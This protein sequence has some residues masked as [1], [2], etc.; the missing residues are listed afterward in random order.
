[1]PMYWSRIR[2][3]GRDNM[4]SLQFQ[5]HQ[6][7][8]TMSGTGQDL[9][10]DPAQVSFQTIHSVLDNH[11]FAIRYFHFLEPKQNFPNPKAELQKYQLPPIGPWNGHT[12]SGLPDAGNRLKNNYNYYSK[13]IDL[14][15]YSFENNQNESSVSFSAR[16][17]TAP[18]ILVLE[19]RNGAPADLNRLLIPEEDYS[20]LVP[21]FLQNE[22]ILFHQVAPEDLCDGYTRCGPSTICKTQDDV[23]CTCLPGFKA[24]YRHD[25]CLYCEEVPDA[26]FT[27]V[28]ADVSLKE[29]ERKCLKSCNCTGYASLNV[30]INGLVCISWYDGKLT[31]IRKF[32]DGQDFCLRV[33]AEERASTRKSQHNFEQGLLCS[34]EYRLF[35]LCL[36]WLYA[37]FTCGEDM[38]KRKVEKRNVLERKGFHDKRSGSQKNHFHHLTCLETLS[39]SPQSKIKHFSSIQDPVYS[40]MEAEKLFLL[41]SLITLQFS[42]CASQDSIETSQVIKEGDLLISKGNNFALGFFSPGSSSNRYLGIWYYKVPEKTVVWVANRNDPIIGSSGSLFINQYG[43]LI[44]YGNDDQKLPVWST[45]V[46]VEE[47]DSC[48]VQ[49]LDSGNLIMVTKRRRSII[50]Q[51]FDHPTNTLLPGMKLGVD[52][53]L[54]IDRILTSWRSADDPGIGDF[55]V[56]IN[57]TGSPQFFIYNGTKPF[58]RS[59]PWPW[60]SQMGLYKSSFVNDQDGIYSH[61]TVPDDSY[62]LKIIVDHSGHAKALARRQSDGLWKDYWKSSQFRCDYYGYCGAYSTCE[63][64]NPSEFVCACLPGFEPKYPEQWSARDGSGGCV[65]KR[66]LT[67]SVCGHGEGFVK[68]EN[69]CLPD[70]SNAAW[71]DNI[72][73]RAACELECKRNCSCSAYSIIGIPGKGDACLTWYK[74][75]VDI[76]Y[77][78]SGSDDLYVRVD[79]YELGAEGASH[80]LY[81]FPAAKNTRKSNVSH[82]KPMLAILVPSIASFW[83][84]ISISAYLWI[85]KRAKKVN[86]VNSNSIE[87]EYFKLSTITAATNNFSPANKLGQGGFGSVYKGLLANGQQVAV[88]RLS[89]SSGQGTEEFKNEVMVIAKLQHRNLVKLLG[90]CI[91]NEEEMLIYE[92][93]PNKSLD[94]FLFDETRRLLLD[95]R[96]RFDIIVGIARGILYLHQDSRLRII[97]RDL[98]CSNILLDAEMNP[99]ISDF[100]MAKIFEGNQTEDRTRRVVGTHG[101]MSP[102]YVVFGKFS[103]KSDVFSFGVMLLEIVSGKKNNRFYQ[104]NPPLTL[105]GYVWELWRQDKALEI[106]DPSLNQLYHPR[107]ALKCIQIGLLCVQEDAMDRPSMLAVVLMLSSETEIPSPKQPAFLFRESHN[108]PDIALAV[109]D[110]LCSINQDSRACLIDSGH[111]PSCGVDLEIAG[112]HPTGPTPVTTNFVAPIK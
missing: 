104:Q 56:R 52:Q 84:L 81:S 3:S 92:H 95:W 49:L 42:W 110:G 61:Y 98:K 89:R 1:M 40:V 53:K 112:M 60:R 22:D 20:T 25:W 19:P 24:L 80:N 6:L 76:R 50:W 77:D 5:D 23:Q 8:S 58:A 108:N 2:E 82:E 111:S 91:H 105:I 26:R 30:T 21:R 75:L 16:N 34:L 28:Y 72:K 18:S 29:C 101:Y 51:S 48:E 69:Y 9:F 70:T 54:G 97:H 55:S 102:E 62:L 33:D 11:S 87:L 109:E 10:S 45:N 78:R 15:I 106:V 66:L 65:R 38:P 88:K 85:K 107:E 73:S 99:K 90:Y 94:S 13:E 93:L 74:E 59:P 86:E 39:N 36:C 41:F 37:A 4:S 27:R 12:L 32:V 64:A 46:S 17:G 7:I 14:F 67:S 31:D 35:F 71:V 83:L 68:I 100:G 43:N 47:N 57:P 63:Y 103:V 44:L 96:K 79:A